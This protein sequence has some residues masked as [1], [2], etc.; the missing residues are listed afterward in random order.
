MSNYSYHRIQLFHIVVTFVIF[1]FQ[2][3]SMALFIMNK[4]Y[5]GMNKPVPIPLSEIARL[6]AIDEIDEVFHAFLD[7]SVSL[8]VSHLIYTMCPL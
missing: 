3:R 6:L 4:A 1:V 8:N 2:I 5:C 7:F